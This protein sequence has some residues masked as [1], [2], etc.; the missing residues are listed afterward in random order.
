MENT[1]IVPRGRGGGTVERLLNGYEVSFWG[2]NVFWNPK[3][4]MVVQHCEGI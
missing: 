4:V 3:K 2:N 1:L